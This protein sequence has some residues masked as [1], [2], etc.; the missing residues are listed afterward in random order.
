VSTPVVSVPVQGPLRSVAAPVLGSA[1]SA[2]LFPVPAASPCILEGRSAS[3]G[4]FALGFHGKPFAVVRSFDWM[5]VHVA[6]SG[7]AV[8]VGRSRSLD[9]A[10]EVELS[11]LVLFDDGA[12]KIDGWYYVA[13]LRPRTHGPAGALAGIATLPPLLGGGSLQVSR[14]CADL[15]LTESPRRF[16]WRGGGPDEP[17][18]PGAVSDLLD[19]PGGTKVA[20]LNVPADLAALSMVGVHNLRAGK[21]FLSI[22]GGDVLAEVWADARVLLASTKPAEAA[23]VTRDL[24]AKELERKAE[25]EREQSARAAPPDLPACPSPS[26]TVFVR[27]GAAVMAV[28]SLHPGALVRSAS[29]PG[30]PDEVPIDLGASGPDALVP[31][32]RASAL[33]RCGEYGEGVDVAA[34]RERGLVYAPQVE[35]R[36]ALMEIALVA[37]SA[38]IAVADRMLAVVRARLRSCYVAG[39]E[40]APTVGGKLRLRVHVEPNG[41][42]SEV[43]EIERLGV[44]SEVSACARGVLRRTTYEPGVSGALTVQASFVPPLHGPLPMP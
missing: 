37:P 42:V 34:Q 24:A 15:S 36:Q 39:L 11:S 29:A 33:T 6:S 2:T 5:E 7:E 28:G 31:F 4:D 26:A 43:E 12:R 20:K 18:A 30:L 27:D 22:R 16:G 44:S 19:A 14:P 17:L 13:S 35:L 1:S 25:A 40:R 32:V 10:G 23:R 38:P 21:V 41:E 8:G 3:A 9:F